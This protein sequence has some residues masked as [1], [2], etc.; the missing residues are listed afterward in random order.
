VLCGGGAMPVKVFLNE[1]I[2]DRWPTTDAL[3]QAK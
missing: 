2:A 1:L 3:D